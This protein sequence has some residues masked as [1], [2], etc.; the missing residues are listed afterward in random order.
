MDDEQLPE[1]FDNPGGPI[2]LSI[3]PGP[4]TYGKVL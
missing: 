2:Y 3:H 1:I 4:R